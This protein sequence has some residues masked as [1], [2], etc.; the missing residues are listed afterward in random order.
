[1]R[2]LKLIDLDK[3][4]LKETFGGTSAWLQKFIDAL[5]NG[6]TIHDPRD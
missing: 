4:E 5:K 6:G 3:F 1:M 2:D